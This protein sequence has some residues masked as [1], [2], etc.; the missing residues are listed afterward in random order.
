M[1]LVLPSLASDH[2]RTQAMFPTLSMPR[3]V[4]YHAQELD[5]DDLE[6][7]CHSLSVHSFN[8]HREKIIYDNMFTESQRNQR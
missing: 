5:E 2:V 4:T 3:M 7:G 1:P 8:I 6:R